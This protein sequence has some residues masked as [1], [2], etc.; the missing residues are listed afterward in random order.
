MKG[1]ENAMEYA[2][3]CDSDYRFMCIVWEN[4][5]VNSGELVKLCQNSKEALF[6]GEEDDYSIINR[7]LK[8]GVSLIVLDDESLEHNFDLI[9]NMDSPSDTMIVGIKEYRELCKMSS[10]F[11]TEGG[12][13]AIYN[14]DG[15]SSFGFCNALRKYKSDETCLI[16]Y[17]K[18]DFFIPKLQK[19]LSAM[20]DGPKIDSYILERM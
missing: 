20:I 8:T 6:I 1:L 13:L 19:P 16:H 14:G 5:P 10:E 17:S 4:A 3:L 11:F 2:K 9:L 15:D 18:G 12:V 7:F